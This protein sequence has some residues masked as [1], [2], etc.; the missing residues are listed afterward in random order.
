MDTTVLVIL[1]LL[2]I[3]MV[4]TYMMKGRRQKRTG[5]GTYTGECMAAAPST[6]DSRFAKAETLNYEDYSDFIKDVSLDPEI[7]KSHQIYTDDVDGSVSGS[8]VNSERSDDN[9]PVPFVGLRRPDYRGVPIGRDARTETSEY[10]DS[11]PRS[12]NFL[13]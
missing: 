11:L 6:F 13:L 4:Y 9:N 1:V 7:Y 2:I 10:T 3:Y 8:S 12:T 5:A